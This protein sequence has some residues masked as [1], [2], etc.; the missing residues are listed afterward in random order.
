MHLLRNIFVSGWQLDSTKITNAT[1][2]LAAYT[3]LQFS[4]WTYPIWL[5]IQD[6]GTNR[7]CSFSMDGVN[8]LVLHTVGRTDHLTADEV[9]FWAAARNGSFGCYANLVSWAVT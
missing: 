1:T 4:G 6:N 8:Y 2:D 7:I 3:S 9:C 5:R